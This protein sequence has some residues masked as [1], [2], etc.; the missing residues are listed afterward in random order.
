MFIK[1][2]NVYHDVHLSAD[3]RNQCKL[4][5]ISFSLIAEVISKGLIK[6]K[7]ELAEFSYK[8]TNVLVNNITGTVIRLGKKK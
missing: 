3:V 2:N 4:S 6:C 1:R 7:G 8:G 5:N